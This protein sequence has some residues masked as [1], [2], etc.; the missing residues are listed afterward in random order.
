MRLSG[1]KALRNRSIATLLDWAETD[2]GLVLAGELVDGVPLRALLDSTGLLP[3]E[4][5][6][7]VLR[8]SLLGAATA[9]WGAVSSRFR[10]TPGQIRG[11]L[12]QAICSAASRGPTVSRLRGGSRSEATCMMLS[13]MCATPGEAS[14]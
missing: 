5:S 1:L 3:V 2:E 7:V 8:D 9:D 4:A 14:R 12:S 11:A 10:L 13:I 6:L